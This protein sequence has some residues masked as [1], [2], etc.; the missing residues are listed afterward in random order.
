MKTKARYVIGLACIMLSQAASLVSAPAAFADKLDGPYTDKSVVDGIR[1]WD[2]REALVSCFA[3]GG[4]KNKVFTLDEI[5][6]EGWFNDKSERVSYYS[7]PTDGT[8][9]CKEDING[10]QAALFK[11]LGWDTPVAAA[12]ALGFKQINIKS[13]NADALIARQVVDGGYTETGFDISQSVFANT[14]TTPTCGTQINGDGNFVFFGA[15]FTNSSGIA[16]VTNA[17][18][19]ARK[20]TSGLDDPQLYV[21]GWEALRLSCKLT[22]ASGDGL[23]EVKSAT[24]NDLVDGSGTA[25]TTDKVKVTVVNQDASLSYVLFPVSKPQGSIDIAPK[26]GDE[27]KGWGMNFN[28][29]DSLAAFV[30]EKAS[31]YQNKITELIA[32]G[33]L[34]GN[35][36][37]DGTSNGTTDT[38]TSCTVDGIGWFVCP[39]AKFLG[40][41]ADGSMGALNNSFYVKSQALFNTK[42]DNQTYVA[43]QQ[44]RNYANILF[45]IAFLIIIFSQITSV[46][47]T[48]YGIKK[49]LPKLIATAVLVNVSFPLCA[50]LVDISNLLGYGLAT[51]LGSAITVDSGTASDVLNSGST[52]TDVLTFI[53]TGGIIGV[54]LYFSL[55][56]VLGA[57]VSVVMIG[58][59]MVV[60]LGIR[61]ALIVLLVVVAP[62]AFVAMLL[63]NTKSLFTKWRK[64]LQSMLLI[65]PIASLLYGGGKLAASILGT[66]GTEPTANNAILK[67]I[68]AALPVISLVAVYKVFTSAMK[69][70]EGIGGAIG[71]LQSG[72]NRGG[73][74]L[75]G[76]VD[77]GVQNSRYGQ[78]RKYRQEEAS[79]RR[80]LIQ[81]GAYDGKGGKLNPGN[82]GSKLNGAINRSR[83]SGKFGDRSAAAGIAASQKIG[84]EQVDN[85]AL[86]MMNGVSSDKEISVAQE[87]YEKALE[88]GDTVK[89]RAAQKVLLGKGGLGVSK[90]RESIEK[91]ESSGRLHGASAAA[92]KK[93]LAS[94]GLKGKDAALDKW[95]YSKDSLDSLTK[96]RDTHSKLTDSELSTQ[97]PASLIAA[98][99]NGSLGAETAAR[100]LGNNNL[101][102]NLTAEARTLLEGLAGPA[103]TVPPT[104]A[105]PQP[106]AAP[107][108]SS[109]QANQPTQPQTT[110]HGGTTYDQTESGLFIP[111]N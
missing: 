61:Q 104:G 48:N 81:A 98:K 69:G 7:D 59:T 37:N 44:I 63:P 9:T 86:R 40:W 22:T 90:I 96:S 16:S 62:L 64:M 25:I 24:S 31:A 45:V 77:K 111:R 47:I 6:L 94:A 18:D 29:C 100:I 76:A 79:R 15:P 8:W 93:D 103:V 72:I 39:I 20:S 33:D 12:C 101:A 67:T 88:S 83:L 95:S 91:A 105:T 75:K 4:L 34:K 68:A 14:Y 87:E 82:W 84:Q 58:V 49:L 89:A 55:A 21:A 3:Q 99:D 110:T 41:I 97:S 50:I 52:F 73:Q 35:D 71:G 19:A 70:L 42:S 60:M 80:A 74:K 54:F 56:A 106:Q 26:T 51:F 57:I 27:N 78:F 66:V 17:I 85:E 23:Y 92:V 10:K 43:W 11:S 32:S 13:E 65:F 53:L 30:S 109:G 28:S 46:G 2:N 1:A 36:T 5:N 38:K 102:N 108:A 107:T